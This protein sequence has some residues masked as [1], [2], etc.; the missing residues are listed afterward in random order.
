M[1]QLVSQS[2]P[3]E[4]RNIV[5][6]AID[7]L[8]NKTHDVESWFQAFDWVMKANGFS[9]KVKGEMLPVKF[10]DKALRHWEVI[11]P[12]LQF[13]QVV[14]CC[15]WLSS[16]SQKT[17][18]NEFHYSTLDF[19]KQMKVLKRLHM[20]FWNWP[21]ERFQRCQRSPRTISAHRT[22]KP[23]IRDKIAAN[24]FTK[25]FTSL[26][27]AKSVE[28]FLKSV[29]KT[30]SLFDDGINAIFGSDHMKQSMPKQ[31]QKGVTFEGKENSTSF[32]Q[33]KLSD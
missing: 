7:T 30:K 26:E 14:E 11:Y 15:W 23:D 17:L 20:T 28:R 1:K 29:P 18:A 21:T 4:N 6:S 25:W 8:R 9:E 12:D 32:T 24:D 2:Q 27:A 3:R 5:D 19:K 22:I 13:T 33:L 10:R 31:S 16:I